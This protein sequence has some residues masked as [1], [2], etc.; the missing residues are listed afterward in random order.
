MYIFYLTSA[1]I[2]RLRHALHLTVKKHASLHSSV[3]ADPITNEMNQQVELLTDEGFSFVTSQIG[4]TK[5]ELEDLVQNEY[6]FGIHDVT[7]GRLVRLHIVRKLNTDSMDDDKISTGDIIIINIRHEGIDGTSMPI[8][9]DSLAQAY[10][11]GELPMKPDDLTYLDYMLYLQ[12]IDLSSSFAYWD[13]LMTSFDFGRHFKQ[14]P[15]D[16]P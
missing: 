11:I 13:Q 12:R 1:S 15:N 3:F 10:T 4:N 14:L 9:F 2:Q 5:N 7:H 8:F 16:R 6:S